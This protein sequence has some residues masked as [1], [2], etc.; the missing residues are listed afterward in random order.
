MS[1]IVLAADYAA[2]L[3]PAAARCGLRTTLELPAP[4]EAAPL[5]S[6]DAA[7]VDRMLLL[8]RATALL[9][10]LVADGDRVRDW[11][12]ATD[13]VSAMGVRRSEADLEL[14][15]PTSNDE[16]VGTL[17]GDLGPG[18]GGSVLANGALLAE[19]RQAG[20]SRDGAASDREPQGEHAAPPDRA[21]ADALV[22][23]RLFA[24]GPDGS[25]VLT[26]AAL[27]ILPAATA[28]SWLAM[29]RRDLD[30]P[31][32]PEEPPAELLFVGP[33][34]R[35]IT[36]LGTDEPDVLLLAD[37]PLDLKS[38]RVL[39]LC[40]PWIYELPCQLEHGHGDGVLDALRGGLRGPA[41]PITRRDVQLQELLDA[42]D[43]DATI[44]LLWAAPVSFRFAARDWEG[45]VVTRSAG[46]ADSAKAVLYRSTR[47]DA[48]ELVETVS[49][50]FAHLLSGELDLPLDDVCGD[51]DEFVVAMSE[52][53]AAT[54]EHATEVGGLPTGV[55]A[56]MRGGWRWCSA[57]VT[58]RPEP[59]LRAGERLTWLSASGNV[60]LLTC[61]DEQTVRG[62]RISGRSIV[63]RLLSA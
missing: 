35:R 12:F 32:P 19:L 30:P 29:V 63:E 17:C 16:L 56:A 4:R 61:D 2:R 57:E 10:V 11:S 59:T 44:A 13:G 9:T 1:T 15:Q 55:A 43:S 5:G 45:H 7:L 38:A 40:A 50:G 51:A 25:V 6:V 58:W 28:S 39:A 54:P 14:G 27:R 20:A 62:R 18:D 41:T 42:R 3:L 21:D 26:T 60:W 53:A 23:S 37:E 46:A 49:A 31:C 24:R 48:G 34:G 47:I 33:P 52:L 22:A 8:A 36:A